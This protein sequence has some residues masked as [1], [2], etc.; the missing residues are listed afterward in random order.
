MLNSINGATAQTYQG[1]ESVKFVSDVI[2]TLETVDYN[3][4][5]N[6]RYG[7][8]PGYTAFKPYLNNRQVAGPH[9]KEIKK[10]IKNGVKL[11][12]PI[13]V[14]IDEDGN[15]MVADGNF[16]MAAVRECHDEGSINDEY[17]LRVIFIHIPKKDV[18]DYIIDLNCGGK[19]WRKWEIIQS[20]A[21]RDA[22][23]LEDKDSYGWKLFTDFCNDP[24]N[25]D[26]FKGAG[27]NRNYG[28]ACRC[29]G[30]ERNG[31]EH[32][33]SP[34]ST[35]TEADIE[36]GQYIK[37]MFMK[38]LGTQNVMT[39]KADERKVA[40]TGGWLETAIVAFRN[41]FLEIT[42]RDEYKAIEFIKVCRD[43]YKENDTAP[44]GKA[45][46]DDWKRY[47]KGVKAEIV[48]RN[49]SL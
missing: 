44:V 2:P 14:N 13:L 24:K 22:D 31:A 27:N 30:L 11:M 35:L 4:I 39:G 5:Y 16:R 20:R 6:Y 10:A 38:F 15:M 26:L 8:F 32:T 34:I 18:E 42:G 45:P 36:N 41:M 46:T 29:I 19:A 33:N 40:A 25:N 7:D 28:Y 12:P 37:D 17:V 23:D 47:F 49:N 1:T 21:K 9:L 48:L 43:L 3:R